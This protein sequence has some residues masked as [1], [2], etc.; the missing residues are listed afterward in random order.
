VDPLPLPQ[1]KPKIGPDDFRF[2]P[3]F[4][5]VNPAPLRR[6]ITEDANIRRGIGATGEVKF[7]DMLIGPGGAIK[8]TG[9]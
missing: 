9:R 3:D 1:P 6:F 8:P 5:V 7:G 4:S 2:E